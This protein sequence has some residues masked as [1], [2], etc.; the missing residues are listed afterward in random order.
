MAAGVAHEV[1]NPLA[2]IGELAGLIEDHIDPDFISDHPHGAL[3]A[4]NLR[5]IQEHVDRARGVTHQMLG[6]A[7]RMEPRQDTV[8]VNAVVED[9]L[10]F[11]DREA[12]FNDIALER[13]LAAGIPLIQTDQSQLQQVMLNVLEN[14]TDAVGPGGRIVVSSRLQG[15][16]IELTVADDGPGIPLAIQ[17]SVFD[18][19][20]TTKDPGEG[21]GLGLSISHSIM[22]QLGGSL[23]FDSRP[24]RGTT[25][26]IRLPHDG[27]Q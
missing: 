25:F 19:F 1:N 17:E 10:S 15:N 27:V 8:N 26:F 7:R 4:D 13:R 18:P 11:V 14:A 20:F 23:S 5:K 12:A 3:F 21:T 16:M 2:A 6:F 9:A 24:G 22:Q